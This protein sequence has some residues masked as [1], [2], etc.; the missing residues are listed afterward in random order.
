MAKLT[1][2]NH[3]V[4]SIDMA[5][6]EYMAAGVSNEDAVASKGDLV[7]LI[8]THNGGSSMRYDQL[9]PL[10]ED[11]VNALKASDAAFKVIKPAELDDLIRETRNNLED[12]GLL[13]V[14]IHA[15]QFGDYYA[16][17]ETVV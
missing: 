2:L 6:M 11:V 1:R 8:S 9:S 7:L 10:G 14:E 17:Y 16:Y 3:E 4:R 15:F 13:D 5:T 12:D